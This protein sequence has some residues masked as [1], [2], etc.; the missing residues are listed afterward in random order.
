MRS[1]YLHLQRERY[2]GHS[3]AWL[4]QWQSSRLLSGPLWVRLLHPARTSGA[5]V[6][7]LAL[8]QTVQGSSPWWS[9]G[10]VL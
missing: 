9:T 6:A 3:H 7:Q 10:R 8:N 4:A 5:M 2:L 1:R